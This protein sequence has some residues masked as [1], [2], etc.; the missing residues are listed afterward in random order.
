M[1]YFC[2]LLCFYPVTDWGSSLKASYTASSLSGMSSTSPN[3][4][5]SLKGNG[6]PSWALSKR[7][8]SDIFP[9][10]VK[11]LNSWSQVHGG[12]CLTPRLRLLHM[13]LLSCWWFHCQGVSTAE[14]WVREEQSIPHV[15]MKSW[16]QVSGCQKGYQRFTDDLRSDAQ[17]SRLLHSCYEQR[18]EPVWI[19][20]G[21]I[22]TDAIMQ[23]QNKAIVCKKV[24]GDKICIYHFKCDLSS[25]GGLTMAGYQVPTKA[26]FHS[27]SSAGQGAKTYWKARG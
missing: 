27:P 21:N 15:Y 24:I 2:S 25:C 20:S 11:T 19:C 23:F 22:N 6:E 1:R 5:F 26:A 9:D 16:E 17:V 8:T 14:T 12:T 4:C 3:S 7:G 13:Y 18:V 10:R